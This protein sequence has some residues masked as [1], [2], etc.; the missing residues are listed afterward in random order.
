MVAKTLILSDIPESN[1]L[2]KQ[3][4]LYINGSKDCL[5]LPSFT[6][7]GMSK[8]CQDLTSKEFDSSHWVPMEASGPVNTALLEWIETKIEKKD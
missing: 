2:L 3:P 7:A 5:S 1:F 8:L 4:V 6:L